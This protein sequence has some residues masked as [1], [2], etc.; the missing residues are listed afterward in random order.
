ENRIGDLAVKHFVRAFEHLEGTAVHH[1][2]A[3]NVADPIAL[4]SRHLG[5]QLRGFLHEIRY[6]S[7]HAVGFQSARG[8][9]MINAAY[10]TAAGTHGRA[11]RISGLNSGYLELDLVE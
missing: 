10:F 9:V 7:F 3:A 11:D 2:A 8:Q 1:S 5:E 4:G 6:K